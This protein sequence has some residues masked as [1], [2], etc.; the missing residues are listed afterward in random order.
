MGCSDPKQMDK[1]QIKADGNCLF[2]AVT[3]AIDHVQTPQE[4]RELIASVMLSDPVTFSKAELGKDPEEYVTWLISSSAA[5]GGIP[6]LKALSNIY[7][8]QLAV[9]VIED[10]QVLVFGK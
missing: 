2:N 9:V 7:Q 4:T 8:T 3:Q 1:V 6:E 5:W 10:Q